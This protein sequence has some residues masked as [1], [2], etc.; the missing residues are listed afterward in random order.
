LLNL[1]TALNELT[2]ESGDIHIHDL[3]NRVRALEQ[4]HG[5]AGSNMPNGDQRKGLN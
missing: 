4:G 3:A 5:D 1:D 2:P